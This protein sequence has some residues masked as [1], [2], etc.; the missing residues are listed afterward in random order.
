MGDALS[1]KPPLQKQKARLKLITI[2]T[3][4]FLIS[5]FVTSEMIVKGTTFGISFSLFEI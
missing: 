3:L 5:L 4:L 2:A 1:P